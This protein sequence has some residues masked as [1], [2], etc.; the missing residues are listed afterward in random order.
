MVDLI[1]LPRSNPG[2][3]LRCFC[4]WLTVNT[5][6]WL[7]FVVENV[8]KEK[9]LASSNIILFCST[10]DVCEKSSFDFCA[11]NSKKGIEPKHISN[12][13]SKAMKWSKPWG[14]LSS[15]SC[16]SPSI[17]SLTAAIFS[18]SF[19]DNTFCEIFLALTIR[20]VS[21]F[22]VSVKTDKYCYDMCRILVSTSNV[23]W[24]L[25]DNVPQSP[26]SSC[27]LSVCSK[28]SLK[29]S[30]ARFLE[31]ARIIK[32]YFRQTGNSFHKHICCKYPQS[33]ALRPWQVHH[34]YRV[35]ECFFHKTLHIWPLISAHQWQS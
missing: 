21:C 20:A 3:H 8:K 31:P 9:P 5:Y 17:K 25:C 14:V 4:G 22:F 2:L 6:R 11:C 7:R 26:G 28:R 35:F 32:T 13:T 29:L 23:L 12:V 34:R 33:A 24:T 18:F 10:T 15:L 16:T 30:L 19:I 1:T 27:S